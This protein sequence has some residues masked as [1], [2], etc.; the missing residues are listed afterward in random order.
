VGGIQPQRL[1]RRYPRAVLR[2]YRAPF[3]TNVERVAIALALKGVETESVWIS[4][5][6]RSPVIEVSGQPL[7][8]VIELEGEVVSDSVAILRWLEERRPDP[9]LF[10]TDA[11]R[12][13]EVDLLIDWFNRVW[14]VAPNAIEAELESERPDHERV[15]ELGA[16]MAA[17]LDRFE[18]LLTGRDWLAGDELSALDLCA[19]PFLK[20]VGGRPPG[21]DERF[22]RI[23]DEHQPATGRH[24]A[25]EGW[26]ERM[27]AL[28]QV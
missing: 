6:D 15:A 5:E 16:E 17:H 12:R 9:P 10:P 27:A 23:L 3:S 28:P 1:T 7:V 19:Y 25:L 18:E 11:A 24:P 4:Y 26:I 20:F 2:L 22:H 21:D 13:A 14:K 8:P